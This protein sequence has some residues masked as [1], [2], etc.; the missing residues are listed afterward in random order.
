MHFGA[1]SRRSCGRAF[2]A[3]ARAGAPA[4]GA[5]AS[6]YNRHSECI[7]VS[8]TR[9]RVCVRACVATFH[10][11]GP[12]DPKYANCCAAGAGRTRAWCAAGPSTPRRCGRSPSRSASASSW[13]N[14][15]CRPPRRRLARSR[16]CRLCA[17]ARALPHYV[18]LDAAPA[19]LPVVGR[20][21]AP[22]THVWRPARGWGVGRSRSALPH[23]W[24]AGT[25]TT[26]SSRRCQRRSTGRA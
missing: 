10:G 13:R 19:A 5:S 12:F 16:W 1:A 7:G 18:A 2:V 25:R 24:R 11:F 4:W 23:G 17:T 6:G 26:P 14:C 8:I 3:D 15:A 21:R 9:M 20:G 22:R